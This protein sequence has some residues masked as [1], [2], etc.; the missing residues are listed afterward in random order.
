[1][2]VGEHE[3]SALTRAH[4]HSSQSVCSG[5]SAFCRTSGRRRARGSRPHRPPVATRCGPET[6]TRE[7]AASLAFCFDFDGVVCD[8]VNESSTAAWKHASQRWPLLDL[9]K[10]PDPFLG[11]MRTVRPVVETGWEN[12]VLIRLLSEAGVGDDLPPPSPS[13][14]RQVPGVMPAYGM[15]L[16]EDS[17][18]G[19]GGGLQMVSIITSNII[20]DWN[21]IR[22]QR[23]KEWSLDTKEMIKEFG[24]VRDCW[25]AEDQ[26]RWL[27]INQPY[28]GVPDIMDAMMQAGAEVFIITTKQRRFCQALLDDFGLEFPAERLFALEDGPKTEVLRSLLARPE[29]A[30]RTF[31][32]V[33]DKLETLRRVAADPDLEG[34]QLHFADWGYNTQRDRRVVGA[35]VVDKISLL[36]LD[37]LEA[38]GVDEPWLE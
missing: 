29:L 26:E 25:I 38:L 7:D 6:P 22:D 16:Q 30:G 3:R 35:G 21:G 9:G 10:T 36:S 12:T 2:V 5:G 33:E 18:S 1:M 32:F 20:S 37:D 31:H 27:A 28:E 11:P 4:P 24:E 17:G 8:S 23:M 19:G 34:I 13:R 15:S 14:I